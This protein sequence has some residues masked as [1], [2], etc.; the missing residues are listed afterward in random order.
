MNA[1][2]GYNG[3]FLCTRCNIRPYYITMNTLDQM[4]R[5]SFVRTLRRERPMMEFREIDDGF[6][7]SMTRQTLFLALAWFVLEGVRSDEFLPTLHV[8]FHDLLSSIGCGTSKQANIRYLCD[9]IH[10][11]VAKVETIAMQSLLL[12]EGFRSL[13]YSQRIVEGPQMPLTRP[14]MGLCLMFARKS[15][16]DLPP[17]TYRRSSACVVKKPWI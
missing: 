10:L 12:M 2:N 1:V 14:W 16:V 17:Y 13:I 5:P 7:I 4:C 9:M 3:M 8:G 11:H 15:I 6:E